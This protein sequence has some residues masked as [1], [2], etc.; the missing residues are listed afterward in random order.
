[1]VLPA[2]KNGFNLPTVWSPNE[3]HY[4]PIPQGVM[5]SSRF[6]TIETNSVLSIPF[7]FPPQSWKMM[8]DFTGT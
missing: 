5:V 4:V 8:T 1:M 7:A 2:Q 6:F 3:N